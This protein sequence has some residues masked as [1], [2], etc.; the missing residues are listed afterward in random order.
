MRLSALAAVTCFSLA[1]F[2]LFL[3]GAAVYAVWPSARAAVLHGAPFTPGVQSAGLIGLA[4]IVLSLALGVCGVSAALAAR[5]RADTNPYTLL[6]TR[7]K[8]RSTVY[9][10]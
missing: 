3:A 8:N 4:F 5:R 2:C 9:G 7:T 10:G 6:S 1:A